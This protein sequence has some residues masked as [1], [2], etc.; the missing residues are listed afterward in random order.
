MNAVGKL[1]NSIESMLIS[2][3]DHCV[4]VLQEHVLA[5]GKYYTLKLFR[6]KEVNH[7]FKLLSHV[8]GENR[9]N[10]KA[11][12]VKCSRLENVGEGHMGILRNVSV[13]FPQV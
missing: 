5:W 8:L 10:D 4:E 1:D 11:N 12:R 2:S 9:I 13:I 6:A 3:F 7:V